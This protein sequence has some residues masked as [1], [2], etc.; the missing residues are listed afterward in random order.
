MM[1][2]SAQKNQTEDISVKKPKNTIILVLTVFSVILCGCPAVTLL[3]RGV[4]SLFDGLSQIAY[5]GEV[6]NNITIS[7]FLN[8]GLICFSGILLLI[9][10]AL[11]IY[12]L[13]QRNKKIPLAPLEPTGVSED[14]PIPPTH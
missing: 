1:V 5:A 8:V 7:I 9:P 4:P 13:V 6:A 14:D 3:F 11:V 12:L 10:L 2:K